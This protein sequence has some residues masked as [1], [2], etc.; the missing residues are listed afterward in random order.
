MEIMTFIKKEI[1]SCNYMLE[2]ELS[3]C[4]K[5]GRA[6]SQD[7]GFYRGLVCSGKQKCPG[8]GNFQGQVAK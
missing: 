6:G 4:G 3:R 5:S 1:E 7:A 8:S 2:K